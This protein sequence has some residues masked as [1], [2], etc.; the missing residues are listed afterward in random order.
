[1]ILGKEELFNFDLS[2]NGTDLFE[3][4]AFKIDA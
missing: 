3:K 4:A 2:G 1:M